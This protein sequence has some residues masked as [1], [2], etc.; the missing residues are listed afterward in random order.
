MYSGVWLEDGKVLHA[1]Y[2]G[3][4]SDHANTCVNQQKAAW[5]E[6][7]FSVSCAS[8]VDMLFTMHL[9]KSKISLKY[10]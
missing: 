3:V 9:S 4:Q 8:H 1:D 6:R 7:D 5:F 2:T 10:R